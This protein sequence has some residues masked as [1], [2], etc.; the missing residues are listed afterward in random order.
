VKHHLALWGP[1]LLYMGVIFYLSSLSD[2]PLPPGL[3]DKPSHSLGYFGFGVVVA[4]AFAGGIPRR[5]GWRTAV[6]AI[7]FAIAYGAS[8]ELH[9]MFVPGRSADVNDLLADTIGASLGAFACWAWGII[10]LPAA[11]HRRAPRHDL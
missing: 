4:R 2:A 3:T 5:F 6:A 1:V 11:T 9:Q 7:V 10:S 8:D